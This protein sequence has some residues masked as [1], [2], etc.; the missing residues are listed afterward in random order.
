MKHNCEKIKDLLD[1]FSEGDLTKQETEYVK[2][3]LNECSTCRREFENMITRSF[4][5]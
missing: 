4:I 2:S 1:S 3:H 5:E